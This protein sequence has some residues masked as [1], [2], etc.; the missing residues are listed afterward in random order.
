MAY[1]WLLAAYPRD[2]RREH[3]AELLEPL[4]AE[5]RR[6]TARETVNLLA[7]GL[8]TRLGR[9]ASRAVVAWAVLTTVVAGLFGAAL[10]SWAGW[11]SAG[12][13]PGPEQ[14]RMLLAGVMPGRQFG[15]IGPPSSFTFRVAGQDLSWLEGNDMVFGRGHDQA[16][17]LVARAPLTD[18][19]DLDAL[20]RT[21]SARLTATG[22]TVHAGPAHLEATRDDSVLTME[23]GP[24]YRE[25]EAAV[26]VR[27]HR[28]TPAGS[29]IGG[30]AGGL[31][32]AAVAFLVFAWASRRTGGPG[33]PAHLAVTIPFGLAMM[34]WCAPMLTALWLVVSALRSRPPQGSP[35][36]WEWLSQPIFFLLSAGGAVFALLSLLLAALPH[37]RELRRTP[38]AARW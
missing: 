35:Q 19:D 16:T 34:F 32:A 26:S 33:H 36:L 22:W 5:S 17:T 18:G 24:A 10:G 13:P 9:P 27:L 14:T 1:A 12:P 30:A 15:V 23:D 25:Q 21:A 38:H 7:H 31:T 11:E 8:R 6:P 28:T 4:L 3:G 20:V 29:W 2:Y 37:R